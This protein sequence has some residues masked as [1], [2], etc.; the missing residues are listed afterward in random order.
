MVVEA[1]VQLKVDPVFNEEL[2]ENIV[3]LQYAAR[4]IVVL[5][6]QLQSRFSFRI[7]PLKAGSVFDQGLDHL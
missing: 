1:S 6:E 2:G 4:Q 3:S 7:D 5:V